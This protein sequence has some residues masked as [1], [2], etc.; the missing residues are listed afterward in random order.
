M[1]VNGQ[2][3]LLLLMRS[4]SPPLAAWIV[5]AVALILAE[6][7][8]VH[9]LRGSRRRSPLVVVYVVAVLVVSGVRAAA[10]VGGRGD[11]RC[12]FW[13]LLLCIACA[14]IRSWHSR[15]LAALVNAGGSGRR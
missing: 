3:V 9:P 10:G 14:G 2:R 15:G 13:L 7:L 6:R 8:V 4:M 11:Q 12:R 1:P 5:V